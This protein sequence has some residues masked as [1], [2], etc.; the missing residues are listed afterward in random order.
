LSITKQRRP[1][2][3]AYIVLCALIL[4]GAEVPCLD[5]GITSGPV[6]VPQSGARDE[7]QP[8]ADRGGQSDH[9]RCVRLRFTQELGDDGIWRRLP[10]RDTLSTFTDQS[11]PSLCPPPFEGNS[12]H[13]V[14]RT[15]SMTA[16][17]VIARCRT[18]VL[19]S[20]A[21][22]DLKPTIARPVSPCGFPL[23]SFL[24]SARFSSSIH[25]R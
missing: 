12:V 10:S 20:N 14:S 16:A 6:D 15:S 22:R 18:N 9:N 4:N 11:H 24:C 7:S 25:V 13:Y 21:V 5:C 17:A 1:S 3:Y 23:P 8:F 2:P 19:L